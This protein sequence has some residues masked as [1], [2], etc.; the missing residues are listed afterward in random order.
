MLKSLFFFLTLVFLTTAAAASDFFN[1][2]QWA[3]E[4]PSKLHM[5]TFVPAGESEKSPREFFYYEQLWSSASSEEKK[6]LHEYADEAK[7]RFGRNCTDVTWDIVSER[8]GSLVTESLARNCSDGVLNYHMVYRFYTADGNVNEALYAAYD[9]K[10]SGLK[11]ISW[12]DQRNRWLNFI[13]SLPRG[14]G[15]AECYL[16][17]H[18]SGDWYCSVELSN[19]TRKNP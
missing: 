1:S 15:P 9:K 3:L 11:D 13:Y 14:V 18:L 19:T 7:D 2:H 8:P 5:M 4:M 17:R 6:T 10:F 16:R 12:K